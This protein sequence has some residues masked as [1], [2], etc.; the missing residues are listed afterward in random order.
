RGES[1][2]FAYVFG[3]DGGYLGVQTEEITKDNLGK[4]GLREVRGV[5]VGE[6]TAGS[7]AQVAGL[8]TGDVIVNFNGEE[9]TSVRKLTRLLSEV[10]PEHQSKLTVLRNGESRDLTV[11]LG[12]R[13]M[14][15]FEDG[16]F[17]LPPAG[18][19]GRLIVPPTGAM[20]TLPPMA[21]LPQIQAMPPMPQMPGGGDNFFVFRG[22]GSG[23]QIGANTRPLTKQL[24]E[25]FG[26][27]GG[28]LV[29]QVREDSPAAKAG[30]KA[31]DIIVEID[32]KEVTGNIDIARA[33][34][35][36]KSGDVELTIVRDRNRQTIRVTPETVSDGP[37]MLQA[38]DANYFSQP[39]SGPNIWNGVTTRSVL[40][41]FLNSPGWCWM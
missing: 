36:K 16:G 7:P 11:T 34:A 31:G 29:D 39:A 18:R 5:G 41:G 10:A 35:A 26:V 22:F 28:V 24:A 6:V 27:T 4:Y 15:K 32:G 33:I 9:V 30:L 21:E 38:P 19:S 1:R 23:R 13:P 3:S 17:A 8:Q 14:P 40:S 37:S 20:P 2:G 12:K 25:H